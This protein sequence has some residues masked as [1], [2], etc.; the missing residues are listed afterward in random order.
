MNL[1]VATNLALDLI[2]QHGLTQQGWRLKFDRS[3][4]RLGQC[5]Y[6]KKIISL[7]Q[8]AT[9]VNDEATVR[10]TILHEIAHALV[11]YGEGHG[12][13]WKEKAIEIGCDGKR[14]GVIAVKAPHKYKMHC[15]DCRYTWEYYRKP[16]IGSF[17]I[18]KCATLLARIGY[19]S[20]QPW[21]LV[22]SNLQVE[23]LA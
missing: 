10:N 21:R 4:R 16:K 14:C 20:G 5:K 2:Y 9:S 23:A 15:L 22:P 1:N 3:V 6:G 11:G 8:Y 13:F 12:P 19:Q 18:H 17:Y 7:G